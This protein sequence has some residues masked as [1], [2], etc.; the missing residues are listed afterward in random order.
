LPIEE[1]GDHRRDILDSRLALEEDAGLGRRE[2][3]REASIFGDGQGTD[4]DW[5]IGPSQAGDQRVRRGIVDLADRIE[6]GGSKR[7]GGR[8]RLGDLTE[9]WESRVDLPESRQLDRNEAKVGRSGP[10][11]LTDP[12]QVNGGSKLASER[13]IGDRA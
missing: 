2:R 9:Y 13:G 4:V 1:R 7:R 11:Q 3:G 10:D 12:G 8:R 6:R 5:Q